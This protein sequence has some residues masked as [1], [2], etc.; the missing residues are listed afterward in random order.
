MKV[1][2]FDRVMYLTNREHHSG[3]LVII[4]RDVKHAKELLRSDKD[5]NVTKEEW[6]KAEV[7]RLAEDAKP[8]FWIMPDAGCC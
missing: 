7:Y 2:I 4:A 8:K 3:G 5:I 1:F 6:L